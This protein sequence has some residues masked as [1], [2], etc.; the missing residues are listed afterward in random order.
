MAAYFI[1]KVFGAKLVLDYRDEWTE[2]PRVVELGN[3]DRF[4]ERRCQQS[5]DAVIF[6]TKSIQDLYLKSF[7]HLDANRCHVLHN[8]W[9][10][11]EFAPHEKL[12][13][14]QSGPGRKLTLS[15]VGY[16]GPYCPPG[17][18]LDV[19]TKVLARNRELRDRLQVRFIGHKSPAAMEQFSCFEN[20]LPGILDLVEYVARRNAI[21][22]MCESS[23]LLLLNEAHIERALTAKL[24][25]YLASGRPILV[26]GNTGEIGHLMRELK[27][28]VMVPVNEPDALERALLKLQSTSASRWCA[29]ARDEFLKT[30]TREVLAKNLFDILERL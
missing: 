7:H 30:H 11:V 8:G 17:N 24:F 26:Y 9:E 1:A 23:A 6:A 14:S 27:A 4:W 3:V 2:G 16:A 10:P 13:D 19:L 29:P 25:E 18:F 5:A 21:R 22:V 28:G 20:H 15:Y 12:D